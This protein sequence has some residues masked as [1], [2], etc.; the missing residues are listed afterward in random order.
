MKQRTK[1]IREHITSEYPEIKDRIKYLKNKYEGE[2]AYVC[3]TGPSFSH[4]DEQFL[5]SFLKDKLVMSIKQ[6]Y[7]TIG[8][9][10]YFHFIL[11]L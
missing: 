9:V 1:E 11:Y 6:T 8:E 2:T 4:Y 3:A 10:S 5:K 7:N